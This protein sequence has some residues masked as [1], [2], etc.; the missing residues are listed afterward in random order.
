[1]TKR[2]TNPRLLYFTSADSKLCLTMQ[3]ARAG[4][5][6]TQYKSVIN[7]R[8]KYKALL[9]VITVWYIQTRSCNTLMSFSR[10]VVCFMRESFSDKA[11]S[12]SRRSLSK[13]SLYTAN[14]QPTI[15]QLIIIIL[16]I[17]IRK[18]ITRALSM[19]RRR[20]QVTMW[21]DGVC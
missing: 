11:R 12:L 4:R 2:Y 7:C 17:I 14:Y 9:T 19:N 10:V 5:L 8:P 15:H 1:M 3:T 6:S 20:G 13:S 18:F 21:P 16:L